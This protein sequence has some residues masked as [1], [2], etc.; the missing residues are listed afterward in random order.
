MKKAVII[1]TRAPVPGRTK[2]RLMP[3][4]TAEECAGLHDAMIRDVLEKCRDLDA[5]IVAAFTPESEEERL[6]AIFGPA[7]PLMPQKGDTLGKRM[8]NAFAAVFSM[9]YEAAV[10]VGTDLPQLDPR[11]VAEAFAGL[12]RC[13]VAICPTPDGGYY[14]IGMKKPCPEVWQISAYSTGSVFAETTARVRASGATVFAGRP[15]G[16]VDMPRDLI[17]LWREMS[18][19][20]EF[21]SS[22]TGRYMAA[23]LREKL[24]RGH[25]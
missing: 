11:A 14:L 8:E 18:A 5:D 7:A 10:L 21:E 12:E 24:E 9:G 2:T 6:R 23:H 4:L 16:D 3:F 22:R 19:A 17:E 20:G 15:C 1:F 25:E 13:D